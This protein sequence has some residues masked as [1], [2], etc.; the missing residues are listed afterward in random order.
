MIPTFMK[1]V[2]NGSQAVTGKYTL[3]VSSDEMVSRVPIIL[4]FPLGPSVTKEKSPSVKFIFTLG[5]IE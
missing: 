1:E 5:K 3:C 2:G 4:R